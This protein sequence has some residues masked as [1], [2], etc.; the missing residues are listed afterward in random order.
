MSAST[1]PYWRL[2]SFYGFYFASLGALAPFWGLYLQSLGFSAAEIGELMAVVLGTKVIAPTFWGWIAERTGL[3][4]ALVRIASFICVLLFLGVFLGNDFWWLVLVMGG[5]SFFWNASLPQ[6]E[7]ATLNHL[8][9]DVHRYTRIRL[10][11]SL[12][13]VVTVA[14]L[15]PTLERYGVGLLPWAMVFLYLGIWFSSLWVA[16]PPDPPHPEHHDPLRRV[17]RRPE[18]LTFLLACFLL[19]AGHGAYYGFY[20][21]YLESEGYSKSL[22]GQLWALGVIAE[23]VVFVVMHRLLDRFGAARVLAWSLGLAA[24]RWVLIGNFVES[25]PML[26]F[27]Q[28]LHAASFGTY[29]ASAIQLVHRYFRGRNQGMGQALYSSV[30][31]GAGGALG[32]LGSGYLWDSVGPWATFM[33]AA[34]VGSLAWAFAQWGV[35]RERK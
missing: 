15:G 25:L 30:S 34:A 20:S 13:F 24:I 23:V 26:L 35:S 33:I 11:G 16:E 6:F 10:W 28:I 32:T 8:G 2:S 7:A 31:F 9:N 19:Q 1:V 29:H 5:F 4:L 3:R 12:G 14:A 18:V 21:I 17:L 22:I 27:A